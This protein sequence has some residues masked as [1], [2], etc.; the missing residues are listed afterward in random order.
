[1]DAVQAGQGGLRLDDF[2][3]PFSVEEFENKIL[4]RAGLGGVWA[5]AVGA[6]DSQRMLKALEQAS[7]EVAAIQEE[8][9]TQ[10]RDAT[11]AEEQLIRSHGERIRSLRRQADHVLAGVT[12]V[13]ERVATVGGKA[14]EMG[15]ELDKLDIERRRAKEAGAAIRIF[16]QLASEDEVTV[17]EGLA[18]LMP[19]SGAEEYIANVL[20]K[21]EAVA[22][23]AGGDGAARA[24]PHIEEATQVLETAITD[25]YD[26]AAASFEA[27]G[28]ADAVGR[29]RA[30]AHALVRFNGGA[31]V[32]QRHI[33]TRP[34]FFRPELVTP[35]VPAVGDPP[36][37]LP[38]VLR[39][40]SSLPSY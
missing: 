10:L 31:A 34:V 15:L 1:M 22:K 21:V 16:D 9:L 37:P 26:E 11:A 8:A 14:V 35:G 33:A 39:Q 3:G 20:R 17:A 38:S 32:A 7:A 40:A 12:A 25:R 36:P 19:G 23:A 6:F 24:K 4:E 28:A 27:S 2:Q 29:M 13:E 30:C 5:G 18:A